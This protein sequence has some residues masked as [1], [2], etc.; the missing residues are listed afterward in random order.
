MLRP[1]LYLSA[2]VW[3]QEAF[4]EATSRFNADC[5]EKKFMGA[6]AVRHHGKAVF[7]AACGFANAEWETPN[8]VDTKFRA[9]SISKQF[10]A[11]AVLLLQQE[12]KLT[13]GNSIGTFIDGLPSA[14]ASS[15]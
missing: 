7:E 4:S 14:I 11:A 6:V 9:A 8:T 15:E 12:G 13:V 5:T 3:A 10:T 2:S 1:W